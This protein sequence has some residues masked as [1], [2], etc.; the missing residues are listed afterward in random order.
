MCGVTFLRKSLII[1]CSAEV[2][3]IYG[4]ILSKRRRDTDVFQG[5]LAIFCREDSVVMCGKD[6][7]EVPLISCC[8]EQS[9]FCFDMVELFE[10]RFS[11]KKQDNQRG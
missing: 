8:A 1:Q 6:F 4:R 2:R 11:G 9:V 3:K 5:V 10:H 7:S